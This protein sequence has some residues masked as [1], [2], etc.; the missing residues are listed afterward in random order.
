MVASSRV[1]FTK[2]KPSPGPEV[3]LPVMSRGKSLTIWCNAKLSPD[4]LALLKEGTS[5]HR[6]VGPAAGGPEDA[7]H[8][9]EAD[10]AFGQP[11]AGAI[12]HRPHLAWIQVN[13]AGYTTFDRADVRAAL[14]GRGAALT[15]SSAVYDE[16]CAQ[17]L[18]AFML[19]QARQLPWAL[20]NAAGKREWP[21]AAVRAQSVLL[22]GQTV[23]LVGF[24]SIARR[25]VE[26]LAPLR[27]Q[28]F[29]LR[30]AVAGDEPVPTFALD[31]PD[32]ARL[33]GAA[34]HVVNLLPAS[35]ATANAFDASRLA[36]LKPGA[37]FYNIG[38]GTTVDQA[39]LISA[40][41]G[42]RLAAAYLDVT[43]PEPLPPDHPL[44]RAPNCFISPH[45]AGGHKTEFVRQVRHFLENLARFTAGQPLLDRVF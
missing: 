37:V 21:V 24:G 13:S 16:P 28:L 23:V 19:A 32:A 45:T 31:G 7:A 15:K 3:E 8:L 26:L 34:D 33:L 39:A 36:A 22:G 4:A 1:A 43:E 40:L 2:A 30:R 11:D 20:S 17:H 38:R 27:L 5:E 25:L 44:W 42:G 10:V 18:L 6:L 41:E 9:D 14:Q 35:P 29:G 12:L